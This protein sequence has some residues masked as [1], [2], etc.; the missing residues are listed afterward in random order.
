MKISGV[1]AIV[2]TVNGKRYVG[3]SKN[4]RSRLNEHERHLRKNEHTNKRLQRAWNKYS[5]ECF[6]FVV[7]EECCVDNLLTREQVYINERSEYNVRKN[8]WANYGLVP[9]EETKRRM[10]AAKKGRKFSEEHKANLTKARRNRKPLAK[11]IKRLSEETRRKMS[12]AA[13]RRSPITEESRARMRAA[14]KGRKGHPHTAEELRKMSIAQIGRTHT[15]ETRR[16]ISKRKIGKR[17]HSKLNEDKVREIRKL[18][19]AGDHSYDILAEMFKVSPGA[20]AFV[21]RRVTWKDVE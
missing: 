18:Y 12:E 5:E 6:Q 15:E 21:I 11:P 14:Q 9:T 1:Y 16:K 8:A 17:A 2:N 20:V 10:S 7:I 19:A 3:S 13:R 4:V